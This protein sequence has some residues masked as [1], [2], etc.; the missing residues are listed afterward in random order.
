MKIQNGVYLLIGN[1]L[2]EVKN[3][4][5]E[6]DA[7]VAVVYEGAVVV[8]SPKNLGAADYDEAMRIAKENG[9]KLG[10]TPDWVIVG[11]YITD[12]NHALKLLGYD[13]IEGEYWTGTEYSSNFAWFY[14]TN[15]YVSYYIKSLS[16]YVRPLSSFPLNTLIL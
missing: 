4:N 15:G 11:L 2:K 14:Y 16:L 3:Y 9:S 12:V 7:K 5:N 8:V 6:P 13:V 10:N 1:E